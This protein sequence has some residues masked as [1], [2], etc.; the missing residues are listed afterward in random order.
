MNLRL[1]KIYPPYLQII[2]G[3]LTIILGFL[4]YFDYY[5]VWY[6]IVDISIILLT[7]YTITSVITNEPESKKLK[8][9]LSFE[10]LISFLS[11][12]FI[13]YFS[14]IYVSIFPLIIGF[15]ILFLALSRFIRAYIYF[16]DKL[17]HKYLVLLDAIISLIFAIGLITHPLKNINYLS[18][19]LAF[20]FMFYG[21]SFIVK[22]FNR[23]FV[24]SDAQFSLPVPV[25]IGAFLPG[26]ALDNIDLITSNEVEDVEVDLEVFI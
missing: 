19:W 18:Y 20:Y 24:A 23:L 11:I 16:T 2:A 10:T 3:I 25:F 26:N 14:E 7:I 15:Y 5:Y 13:Y 6:K 21:F 1:N 9:N 17:K 4:F 22:G 12:L 8:I